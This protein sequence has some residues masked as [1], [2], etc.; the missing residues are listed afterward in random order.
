MFD[1]LQLDRWDNISF[2]FD[3]W[4]KAYSSSIFEVFQTSMS[5][6]Y[7]KRKINIE[8]IRAQVVPTFEEEL[9]R[10]IGTY[11]LSC[12]P[13]CVRLPDSECKA[14]CF[15][16]LS[17]FAMPAYYSNELLVLSFRIYFCPHEQLLQS[18]YNRF[19]SILS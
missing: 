15:V 8:K 5:I 10:I 14:V 1:F 4:I 7:S 18:S 2:I 13:T 19:A 17:S 6:L 11:F 9:N 12:A 16:C 3:C